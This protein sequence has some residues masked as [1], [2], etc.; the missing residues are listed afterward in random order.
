MLWGPQDMTASLEEQRDR[1][2]L[3]GLHT[4]WNSWLTS[5]SLGVAGP[6]AWPQACICG[7]WGVNEIVD[8]AGKVRGALLPGR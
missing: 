2:C 8:H 1:K 5:P 3:V 4:A 6:V 7:T